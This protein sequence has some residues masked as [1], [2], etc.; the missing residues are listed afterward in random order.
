MTT[1]KISIKDVASRAKVS[2]TTVSRVINKVPTVN[3]RNVARVEEAVLALKYRPNISAQRLASGSNNTIGLIMPGYPGIFHS[4]FAIELIRGVGHACESLRLDMVFHISDGNAPLSIN[5]LGGIVFADIIENRKQVESAIA[6]NMQCMVINNVVQDLDV[7][8]IAVNN[9]KG[10]KLAAE[11]LTGLGHKRI[12]GITG[13]LKTQAGFDRFDGFMKGLDEAKIDVPKEYIY[14]GDYS[15]RS[16]RQAAEF[17]FSMD[18]K[19]RPTAIF[20]QSDDMALEVIAVAYEM[21][22]RVPEDV[23]VIGFDDNPQAIY[24]PVGLTTIRQPIFEMAERA[25]RTLHE[26][27]SGKREEKIKQVLDPELVIRDSCA[28]PS[29]S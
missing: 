19:S 18:P 17:F 14:R 8:Y 1:K 9:L 22:I 29:N 26:M 3:K 11:Y 16:A 4:F 21:G 13:N 15:R 20:A 6:D 25:V 10:G 28:A 12:A 5:Y 7:S 23:S 2:I 24:G 27:M